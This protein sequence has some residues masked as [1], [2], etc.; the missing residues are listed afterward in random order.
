MTDRLWRHPDGW[1]CKIFHK[2]AP[3]DDF[4]DFGDLKT[5]WDTRRQGEALPAWKD[6]ALEDFDGWFGWMVVEDIIPGPRYDAE[7][8]LWGT[9][10]TSL[11]NADLTGQRLSE[12]D[13]KDFTE[14]EYELIEEML[15]EQTISLCTGPMQWQRRSFVRFSRIAL[16]LADDGDTIDKYL[17]VFK[18]LD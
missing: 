6:F 15:N 3:G 7:Y 5:L 9:H 4:G 18:R 2:D 12:T 11:Y 13:G 10:V 8:R 16:P 17:T 14:E 1:T